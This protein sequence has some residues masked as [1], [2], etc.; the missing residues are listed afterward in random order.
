MEMFVLKHSRSYRKDLHGRIGRPLQY[1]E[2]TKDEKEDISLAQPLLFMNQ[3]EWP[4]ILL[5]KNLPTETPVE[6]YLIHNL[7]FQQMPEI[8]VHI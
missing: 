8:K 6:M 7:D 5:W 2:N 1:V 3:L 4:F